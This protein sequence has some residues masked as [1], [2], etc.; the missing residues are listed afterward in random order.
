MLWLDKTLGV[1]LQSTHMRSL[2]QRLLT[3]IGI[4]F[5]GE[6]YSCGVFFKIRRAYATKNSGYR[7]NIWFNSSCLL[8]S[9]ILDA[10]TLTRKANLAFRPFLSS[11]NVLLC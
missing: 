5:T 3:P 8:D 2:Y 4:I 11:G 6:H 7:C 9:E 10:L 1:D